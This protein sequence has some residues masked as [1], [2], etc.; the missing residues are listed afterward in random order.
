MNYKCIAASLT[1]SCIRNCVGLHL[2][3]AHV[4]GSPLSFQGGVPDSRDCSKGRVPCM[5]R[6]GETTRL[7]Q[8][9]HGEAPVRVAAQ[10]DHGAHDHV[11]AKDHLSHIQRLHLR[12]TQQPRQ[13]AGEPCLCVSIDSTPIV[14]Q[15]GC[16]CGAFL[17][18]RQ[19]RELPLLCAKPAKKCRWHGGKM[20]SP[21]PQRHRQQQGHRRRPGHSPSWPQPNR[22]R[23]W[24]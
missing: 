11:G 20:Y 6:P 17:Y 12:H 16:L 13:L 1:C 15:T 9:V 7:Q 5:A 21:A 24:W 19:E 22:C 18:S 14:K 3:A 2:V 23:S 4:R 8:Q 10:A